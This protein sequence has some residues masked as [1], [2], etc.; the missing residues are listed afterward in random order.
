MPAKLKQEIKG[1]AVAALELMIMIFL[2]NLYATNATSSTAHNNTS[3]QNNQG[4]AKESYNF[5]DGSHVRTLLIRNGNSKSYPKFGFGFLRNSTTDEIFYLV[6]VRFT[7]EI[8]SS[9][10]HLNHP[11]VILWFANGQ[12]PVKENATLEFTADGDLMLKDVDG[13]RVWSAETSGSNVTRI[14]LDGNGNLRLYGAE[15]QPHWTSFLH[16]TNT[17]LA[18]QRLPVHKMMAST[19]STTNLS[20]GKFFLSLSPKGIE[21]FLNMSTV[22]RFQTIPYRNYFLNMSSVVLNKSANLVFNKSGNH[23]TYEVTPRSNFHYMRLEPNGHLNIY[24]LDNGYSDNVDLSRDEHYGDCIY[25]T[26][27]GNYGVCFDGECTCPGSSS[28][29]KQSNDSG[30]GNGFSCAAVTHLSC[31]L[32]HLQIF[33]KLENVTYF[34]FV[35]HLINT[36]A[37]GCQ[38]ACLGNCSCKAALFR[39]QGSH[40]TGNCSLPTELYTLRNNTKVISGYNDIIFIKV[41]MLS[42]QNKISLLFMLLLSVSAFLLLVIGTSIYFYKRWWE[43]KRRD[44]S[45]DESS[46]HVANHLV[47]FSSKVMKSATRD[48]QVRL[49]RGGSGFAFEGFLTDGTKV[50]VKRLHPGENR[51][52]KEFLSEVETIGNIHHFNL[53][54]LV[55][56]CAE[57]SNRLLV[58]EYMCNGSLDKWIYDKN[59]AETL[60][61]ETRKKIICQISRGLEYLHEYCNPKIIHFDIKPQNILLDGDLNVKISDFGLARLID[62]DH[63]HVST[64]PKGTPGYMAPELT[65]GNNITAKIDIYSFG[66]VILEIICGR[67]SSNPNGGDYLVDKLKVKAEADRLSDLID[68]QSEDMQSHRDDAVKMIQIAISCLQKNLHRRP[69]ATMLIKILEGLT[70]LEP[71]TDYGFLSFAVGE[72]TPQE[73]NPIRSSPITASTLSGPR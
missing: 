28:Y 3:W 22:K 19:N 27:C 6:T 68:Q 37:E 49:G 42:D 31:E 38:R 23:V 17:W 67:R 62:Q 72:E 9:P 34:D 2:M 39:Y 36:D 63:S 46:V 69:S 21:V 73:V 48:F 58:Y 33:L 25:P 12:S 66:V 56:Y 52:K 55:G 50:A 5:V 4:S 41:Q 16:P 30:S 11:P 14:T 32:M 18:G 24:Q 71:V 8:T 43:G 57:R 47:Q 59:R 29:F 1:M 40:S 26:K 53:V 15:K 70:N 54:R 44:K 20:Q 10:D 13:T 65:R 61:W 51:G 64:M 35:P 45:I 60:T 7:G